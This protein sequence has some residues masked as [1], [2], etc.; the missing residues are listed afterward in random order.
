[1]DISKAY[2]TV[3]HGKLWQVLASL[4]IKGTWLENMKE[5]YN[6]NI[7]KSITPYGKTKGVAVRRGIRQGCP[8]S[9]LLFALYVEPI[10][11]AMKKVNPRPEEEP[12]MLAYA[13]DM[14]V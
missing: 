7:I 5:L 10:T 2:D 1:M 9:P 13:D 11:R 6:N 8:L 4:G 12:S 3:D 14:A